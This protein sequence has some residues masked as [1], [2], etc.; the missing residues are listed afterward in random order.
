M[1]SSNETPTL[2]IARINVNIHIVFRSTRSW[3][4]A[5]EASAAREIH[6]LLEALVLRI[7]TDSHAPFP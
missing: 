2:P 3:P 7:P 6:L 5:V 4:S 1:L